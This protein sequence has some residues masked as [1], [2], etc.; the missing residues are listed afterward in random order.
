MIEVRRAALLLVFLLFA[1]SCGQKQGVHV[2]IAPGTA[3][4]PVEAPSP[5]VDPVTGQLLDPATGQPVPGAGAGTSTTP[6]SPGTTGSPATSGTGPTNAEGETSTTAPDP[7]NQDSTPSARGTSPGTRSPRQG[8]RPPQGDAPQGDSTGITDTEIVIGFHAPITGAAPLPQASF[9]KGLT[10]YWN[11]RGKVDGRTV[12]I[13][14]EDDGYNP[15]RAASVCKKMIEKDKVFALG[16]GGGADQ[17][18]A[19]ARIAAQHG[20]PYISAGVDEGL[21]R[22]LPN[23][24]A[25]S[26]SY[27]QQAPLLM[28]WVKKNAM[29]ANKKFAILRDRTPSFN[30]VV[31]IME[32]EARK[33]GLEPIVRQ[34][35]NG[36]SDGQWLAANQIKTAF[37]IM[38]PSTWVQIAQSPGGAIDNWVGIGLTMG[39][40]SVSNAACPAIEGAMFFSPFP[41]F[42]QAD[43]LDPN[44]K[45]HGGKDDI[46]WALWGSNK[47]LDLTFRAMKGTH[48]REA[49]IHALET[50]QIKTNIYPPSNHTRSNHFGVREV[51][52]LRANCDTR[53]WETPDDGLF[54]SSF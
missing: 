21:L 9:R 53:E 32:R 30:N 8:T 20:V 18:A 11:Y 35:Q 17:I 45:R 13:I 39:L 52:V 47:M 12:R 4:A 23:Y 50:S 29:P 49:F 2:A 54:R 7:Q 44:F 40:N 37:P 26:M 38:S 41:G 14:V 36:P 16:G 43:N 34:V 24:F 42:N 10:Q 51:H 5:L 1:A 27:P 25:F 48:T 22:Q 19:C 15:S 28:Q 6:G 46:Q 33:I 3:G 31:A